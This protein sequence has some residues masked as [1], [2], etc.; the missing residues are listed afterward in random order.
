MQTG[1][2]Q[3]GTHHL[4]SPQNRQ[5]RR[6]PLLDPPALAPASAARPRRPRRLAS[7]GRRLQLRCRHL[8]RRLVLQRR[9]PQQL[10]SVLLFLAIRSCSGSR[11]CPAAAAAT[12]ATTTT[13]AAAAAA[14]ATAAAAAAAAVP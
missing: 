2:A 5:F 13:A 10:V 14:A 4:G 9:S 7:D 6:T 3:R 8:L 12:T 11:S 1:S